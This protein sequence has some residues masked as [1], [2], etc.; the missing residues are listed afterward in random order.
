MEK[1]EENK[2]TTATAAKK[3]V[4][5]T[6]KK[7]T[8]EK[9]ERKVYIGPGSSKFGVVKDAIFKG[10]IPKTAEVFFEKYPLAKKLVID[11]DKLHEAKRKLDV[12]SSFEYVTY[13]KVQRLM[14]GGANKKVQNIKKGETK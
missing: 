6:I 7:N 1:K 2:K 5:K 14:K 4:K 3:D 9:I 8:K 13:K 12:K 11:L 10:G